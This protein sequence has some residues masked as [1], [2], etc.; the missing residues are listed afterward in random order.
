M[1]PDT[2]SST[3]R[4]T[5]RLGAVAID[6]GDPPA[7]GAFYSELTGRPIAYSSPD[8]LALGDTE[9]PADFLG[10]GASQP[11]LTLHR[12]PDHRVPSWPEP[13]TPKQI[14]L[15]FVVA[16]L[17]AAEAF[18]IDIGARKAGTQPQPDNW[19][20]LIDPAGHPFCLSAN[21]QGS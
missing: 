14:H 6:C 3:D 4:P 7:L 16:D 18:A 19:R 8:F 13:G 20:V 9:L 21:F 5:V 12:V 15:D 11:W 10:Q 17:D 1:T 2:A